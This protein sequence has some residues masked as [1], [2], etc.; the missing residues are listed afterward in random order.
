M[1]TDKTDWLICTWSAIG[2]RHDKRKTLSFSLNLTKLPR[3]KE[4]FWDLIVIKPRPEQDWRENRT[5]DIQKY[6]LHINML[7]SSRLMLQKNKIDM[8]YMTRP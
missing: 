3:T 7:L 1:T 6:A 4:D 8:I 5:I 2:K